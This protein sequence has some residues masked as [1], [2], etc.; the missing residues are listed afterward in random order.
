MD[1]NRRCRDRVTIKMMARDA[2]SRSGETSVRVQA[3]GLGLTGDFDGISTTKPELAKV[4]VKELPCCLSCCAWWPWSM[5]GLTKQ[6]PL[7]FSAWAEA[8]VRSHLGSWPGALAAGQELLQKGRWSSPLRPSLSIAAC[9]TQE[10][11]VPGLAF[12]C[13]EGRPLVP[14]CGGV[15]RT[16]WLCSQLQWTG[17]DWL[18]PA[19]VSQGLAGGRC[20][21][22]TP[23]AG[24]ERCWPTYCVRESLPALPSSVGTAP[25][26]ECCGAGASCRAVSLRSHSLSS[27]HL[28]TPAILN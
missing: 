1:E 16:T 9:S 12:S 14:H 23:A 15:W 17:R 3:L 2:V 21:A 26:S 11:D 13:T 27:W 24:A 18:A 4:F 28:I 7:C 10:Q 25:G 19:R 20:P 6:L 22:S 5:V 8:A